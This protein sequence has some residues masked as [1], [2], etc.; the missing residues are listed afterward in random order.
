MHQESQQS[1]EACERAIDG[2]LRLHDLTAANEDETPQAEVVRS[3]LEE[4]WA[5]LS[6][7]ERRQVTG[8]SK[9]LYSITD[10]VAVPLPE[11]PQSRK[12]LNEA[13]VSLTSGDWEG[14]LDLLRRWSRYV[15][16][17]ELAYR[18]GR[19]WQQAR[20]YAVAAVFFQHASEI[21][22]SNGNYAGV[23]LHM[24]EKSD[25]A[26]ASKKANEILASH[27][28]YPPQMVVVAAS[29]RLA[30]SVE[31]PAADRRSI[32][33][34]LSGVL[35]SAQERLEGSNA[36][37]SARATAAAIAGLCEE[38]LGNT[39]AA[40]GHYN[41]GLDIDPTNARVLAARGIAQYG[42]QPHQAVKDFESALRFG[43]TTVWPLFF[44]AHFYLVNGRF[45]ECLKMCELG[46]ERHASDAVK[47]A[48]Y[49]WL[50]I[51]RE[52]LHYGIDD[53]RH[54]FEIAAHLAP[55]DKRIGRNLSAFEASLGDPGIAHPNWDLPPR[56]AV[57]SFGLA[58]FDLVA[59]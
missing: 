17:A 51:C 48:L 55:D 12:R 46:I 27:L 44:L 4:S 41:R 45:Q 21:D 47:A 59:A 31:V 22:P 20:Y 15:Q 39:E 32:L 24:L 2:L 40:I 10:P 57:K 58:E 42:D 28:A 38:L 1:G 35:E 19:L 53:V 26:A 49:E 50:G 13:T 36:T 54:A 11:N 23:Y 7:T 5:S 52:E 25:P 9:D 43:A 33:L 16:P 8:L 30:E 3:L 56:D 34:N 29:I 37:S 18:R 6:E 14:A